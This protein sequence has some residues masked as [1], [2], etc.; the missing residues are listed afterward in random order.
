MPAH[1]ANAYGETSDYLFNNYDRVT[2]QS[3]WFGW[4]SEFQVNQ[5]KQT[6]FLKPYCFDTSFYE[7]LESEL[8]K[9]TECGGLCEYVSL[10]KSLLPLCNSTQDYECSKGVIIREVKDEAHKC[11]QQKSC[12][13]FR[14]DLK[15]FHYTSDYTRNKLTFEYTFETPISSEGSRQSLPYKVVYTEYLIWI[16]IQ[17]IA[18]VG[19]TLGLTLGQALFFS[20]FKTIHLLDH[21]CI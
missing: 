13:E 21:N 1:Q 4:A 12:I 2:W 18:N 8:E 5:F 10:P 16:D 19:G 20:T 15:N 9:N 6:N 11:R 17:L 7:C 3:I 14:Y